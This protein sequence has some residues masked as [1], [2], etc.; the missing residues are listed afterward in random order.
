MPGI[1]LEVGSGSGAVTGYLAKLI[2][3]GGA[4][5]LHFAT[6][7]NPIAAAVTAR[8]GAVNDVHNL[9]VCCFGAQLIS[10]LTLVDKHDR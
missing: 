9:E 8:T 4:R 1:T 2:A 10:D 7:I 6:D 3:E 5:A